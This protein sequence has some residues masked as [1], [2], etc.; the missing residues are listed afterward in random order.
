[1]IFKKWLKEEEEKIV[2][3]ATAGKTLL[4]PCGYGG[5]CLLPPAYFIPASADAILYISKDDRL[6]NNI[7][8]KNPFKINHLKPK[9]PNNNN[10][11]HNKAGEK[12]LLK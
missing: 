10:E 6:W 4:Y 12:N 5:L 8:E 2:E 3:G 7:G 11:I 9:Q 1:M